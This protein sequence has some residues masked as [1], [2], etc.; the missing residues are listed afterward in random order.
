M[1]SFKEEGVWNFAIFVNDPERTLFDRLDFAT[2][3]I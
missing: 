1:C 3:F 2:K